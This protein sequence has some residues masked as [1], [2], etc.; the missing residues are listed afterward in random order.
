VYG[1]RE[2]AYLQLVTGV[3]LMG[4]PYVLQSVP[5]MIGGALVILGG[6]WAWLRFGA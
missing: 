1:K 3:L 2:S 6:L 5:A 4:E